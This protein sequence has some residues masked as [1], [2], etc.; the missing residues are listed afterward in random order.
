MCDNEPK[1]SE[2]N[3]VKGINEFDGRNYVLVMHCPSLSGDQIKS[4]VKLL[5]KG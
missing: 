5:N 1:Y 4:I 3:S 2:S